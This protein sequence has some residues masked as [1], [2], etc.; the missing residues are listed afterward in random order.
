MGRRR[1]LQLFARTGCG[2]LTFVVIVDASPFR[3]AGQVQ[4]AP[5]TERIAALWGPHSRQP[6]SSTTNQLI[7][8][9]SRFTYARSVLNLMFLSLCVLSL[10]PLVGSF[11]QLYSIAQHRRYKYTKQSP[12]SKT[13]VGRSS[14]QQPRNAANE[15]DRKHVR[16]WQSY[17]AHLRNSQPRHRDYRAR[18]KDYGPEVQCFSG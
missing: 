6:R 15:V 1:Q 10:T 17:G 2:V 14:T 13:T 11:G 9:K 7:I 12:P 8:I 18:K 3:P 4:E 16:I 5:S